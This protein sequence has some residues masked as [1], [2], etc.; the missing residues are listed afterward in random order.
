MQL[1]NLME[2]IVKSCLKELMQH[3]EELSGLD[4]KAQADISAITLNHLP[5]KYVVT[6]P[7]EVFAKTQLRN[8]V[9][10]DVYRELAVA[11]DKVL[12]SQRKS[13]F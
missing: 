2:D 11:I 9:E 8:Q 1:H 12:N 10:T 6:A 7:G 5:A 13:D 3:K 4:D